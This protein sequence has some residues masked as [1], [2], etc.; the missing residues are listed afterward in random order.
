LYYIDAKR[1]IYTLDDDA[2]IL[3]GRF[4]VAED[5]DEDINWTK[6]ANG[7]HVAHLLAVSH[8]MFINYI[9]FQLSL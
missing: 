1:H 8:Y 9:K 4:A 7:D 3:K 5:E 2:W 6:M